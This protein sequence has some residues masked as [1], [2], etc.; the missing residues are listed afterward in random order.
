[1]VKHSQSGKA[2]SSIMSLSLERRSWSFLHSLCVFVK[3]LLRGGSTRQ[4]ASPLFWLLLPVPLC[5]LNT[6]TQTNIYYGSKAGQAFRTGAVHSRPGPRQHIL[7]LVGTTHMS[8]MDMQLSQGPGMRRFKPDITNSCFW[9]SI[10]Q[11][12]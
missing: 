10:C 2:F 8:E 5:V 6:H 7:N 12:L 11:M 3:A 4:R 1:M 9:C